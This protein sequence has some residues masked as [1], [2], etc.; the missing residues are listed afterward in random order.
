MQRG[1]RSALV[2][3]RREKYQGFAA[4]E[5]LMGSDW[6]DAAGFAAAGALGGF[7]YWGSNLVFTH[8][9]TILR[10]R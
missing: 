8:L 3:R 6:L 4:E 10:S 7:I 1:C 9:R 2:K 5:I